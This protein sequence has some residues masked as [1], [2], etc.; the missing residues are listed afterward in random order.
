MR[1]HSQ[2]KLEALL[3]TM[4]YMCELQPSV[5]KLAAERTTTKTMGLFRI[6][7]EFVMSSV[8]WGREEEEHIVSCRLTLGVQAADAAYANYRNLTLLAS[9]ARCASACKFLVPSFLAI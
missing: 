6:C 7:C 3:F 4:G 1:S 8:G 5:Y 9:R 2:D